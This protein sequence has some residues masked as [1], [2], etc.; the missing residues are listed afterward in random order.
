MHPV[1]FKPVDGMSLEI[2]T[3]LEEMKWDKDAK[4]VV[5]KLTHRSSHL[6]LQVLLNGCCA[7]RCSS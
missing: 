3:G 5:V 4:L 2:G 7:Y 6:V 1:P